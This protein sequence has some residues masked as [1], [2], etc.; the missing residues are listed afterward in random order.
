MPKD[1]ER[2]KYCVEYNG[3]CVEE[4]CGFDYYSCDLKNKEDLEKYG[5][6]WS[7]DNRV[8]EDECTH[9]L[10]ENCLF[11]KENNN[12]SNEE[13]TV[14]NTNDWEKCIDIMEKYWNDDYGTFDIEEKNNNIT[15]TLTT[16]GWSENEEII[17]LISGTMFW[18]LWWQESKRGGYY[19]FTM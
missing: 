15:L 13:L 10:C 18:F 16:G 7:F 19:K 12:M 11:R 1:K 3:D 4:A 14:F 17:N 6:Y 2:C 5:T 8:D 9:Y